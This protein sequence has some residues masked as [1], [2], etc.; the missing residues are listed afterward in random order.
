M[1]VT[2]YFTETILILVIRPQRTKKKNDQE[3]RSKID[4]N[5]QQKGK[6][7][8]IYKNKLRRKCVSSVVKLE[9]KISKIS[10]R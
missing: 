5:N 8:R 3:R 10:Y 9:K 7:Y 4:F 2:I 6:M 1:F